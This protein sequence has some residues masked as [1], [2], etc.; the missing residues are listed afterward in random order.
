M[1]SLRLTVVGMPVI[2]I[3]S[4]Y[5]FTTYVEGGLDVFRD[6]CWSYTQS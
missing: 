1:E 4:P 6:D 2:D 3:K 5:L